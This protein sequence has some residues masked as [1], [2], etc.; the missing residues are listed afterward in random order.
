VYI[1]VAQ[2]GTMWYKFG[3][4][5]QNF[6]EIRYTEDIY[7]HNIVCFHG[8]FKYNTHYVTI[9]IYIYLLTKNKIDDEKH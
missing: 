7:S 9:K 3:H 2:F 1:I 4:V 8:M 6:Q 5:V